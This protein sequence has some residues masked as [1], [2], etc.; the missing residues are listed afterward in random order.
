MIISRN[1]PDLREILFSSQEE[2]ADYLDTQPLLYSACRLRKTPGL[3]RHWLFANDWPE[4]ML[5]VFQVQSLDFAYEP[6]HKKWVI[7]N[8]AEED[9]PPMRLA[10]WYMID[11][12][13]L[14]AEATH[15]ELL[16]AAW[17]TAQT[18][19]DIMMFKL[20]SPQHLMIAENQMSAQEFLS[21]HA[22]TYYRYM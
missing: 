13:V 11:G 18:F 17:E 9:W 4:L 12:R 8:L 22:T 3:I 20:F 7:T 21:K 16:L 6:E 19:D 10:L 14:G 2:L 1:E 5:A 15:D